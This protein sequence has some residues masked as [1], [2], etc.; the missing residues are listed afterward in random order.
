MV[1]LPTY[2]C[3]CRASKRLTPPAKCTV[4]G[5]A[6]KSRGICHGGLRVAREPVRHRLA[7]RTI[8]PAYFFM[9]LLASLP[10][11]RNAVMAG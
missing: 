5:A 11:V 9:I 7:N 2:S 6:K 4:P 3:P 10:A 8:R 1:R